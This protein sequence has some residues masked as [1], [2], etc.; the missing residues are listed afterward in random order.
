MGKGWQ[1]EGVDCTRFS[2]GSHILFLHNTI[3]LSCRCRGVV[4]APGSPNICKLERERKSGLFGH[5]DSASFLFES[6]F[7]RRI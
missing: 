2:Q 1:V 4:H 6:S 7:M 3:Q 5:S